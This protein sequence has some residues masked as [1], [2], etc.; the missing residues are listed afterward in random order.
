MEPIR[1]G[2][3]LRCDCMR[4]RIA[5]TWFTARLPRPA[6]VRRLASSKDTGAQFTQY[7][8]NTAGTLTS[9]LQLV[10]TEPPCGTPTPTPT[11]TATP[12]CTPGWSAGAP[13]PSPGVR[14][15]GVYFP[16]NGKFYAMG[17]RSADTA[18]SDF[19]HP[20]EYDPAANSLDDQGS[21]LRRQ[22]GQQHGLWGAH[23]RR[24]SLHLLRRRLGSRTRPRLPP[25]CS[26]TTLSRT[27]TP[28]AA[29]WPGD[30]GT[31]LPGG[32]SVLTTS[33]TSSVG[34]TSP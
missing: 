2:P 21:Y 26:S 5:L 8:C 14:S 7:E 29:P 15:V 12:S 3:T 33:C 31:I 16:A 23:R 11:A 17:G 34:S 28:G 18:G 32:F 30:A 25:A 9:G 27:L 22:P 6:Q 24:H 10:F 4:A 20:F 13:L 1:R 19:M